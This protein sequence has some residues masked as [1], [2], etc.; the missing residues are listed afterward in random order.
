MAV[1]AL[2]SLASCGGYRPIEGQPFA[3][4]NGEEVRDARPVRTRELLEG[5]HEL[6]LEAA[7]IMA[8]EGNRDLA[9]RRLE[10]IVAGTFEAIERGEFGLTVFADAQHRQERSRQTNRATMMQFE[11]E[12]S[13]TSAIAGLRQRTPIGTQIETSIGLNR[14]TSNRSPEQQ[15]FRVGLTVTQALLRGVDPAAN[16]AGVRQAELETRASQYQLR[17]FVLALL[18][19]VEVAY[20]ELAL[21]TRRME[22]HAESLAFSEQQLAE[23]ESRI[24]LGDLAPLD[25]AIVRA[26]VARRRQALIDAQAEQEAARLR[27]ARLLGVDPDAG[28]LSLAQEIAIEPRPIEDPS[29]HIELALRLR[30]ELNEARLRLEQNRL[31][32]VVTG[33]GL[34][35][36]LDVFVHLAKTGFGSSFAE[37][38]GNVVEGPTYEAIVGLSFEQLLG[39][40]IA[41]AADE[42]A[43]LRAEQAERAIA[44]LEELVMLDVRLA[45]NEIARAR[46][47]IAASRAT[48][49]LQEQVVAAERE[50][51]E[52]GHITSLLLAQ[53][54]RDLVEAS[55]NEAEALVTYRIALVRLFAAEGSLLERRG[56]RLDGTEPPGSRT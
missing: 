24:E 22:I 9:V 39:N 56:V 19:D 30:P 12:G 26:E 28:S 43:H 55:V 4:V 37:A 47:Q 52:V 49:E 35:P 20:W 44:N 41:R 21:A 18:R 23:V 29:A 27:L 5:N 34:L 32:T 10:P 38:A 50:R 17:A 15:E 36:R 33:N 13:N 31:A 16:L 46:E 53:A 8:L 51:L 3:T 1:L 7:T 40:Q 45:L 54:E 11:V 2:A 6:T 25:A 48:R 14:D 42:G